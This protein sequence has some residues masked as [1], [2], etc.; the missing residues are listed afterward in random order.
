MHRFILCQ[1]YMMFLL[2]LYPPP[3]Y[4]EAEYCLF[5][6]R[7][8]VA[9]ARYRMICLVLPIQPLSFNDGIPLGANIPLR[10]KQKIWSDQFIDLKTLL[11][12]HKDTNISI[13]MDTTSLS[14]SN[15]TSKGQN[16]LSI[17]QWTTAY[18]TFMAIYIERKPEEAPNLLKYGHTIRELA[19]T[20]GDAAW[21]FY[22]ENFLQLRQTT[23]LPWQRTQS[24][25]MV[26][27]TTMHRSNSKSNTNSNSQNNFRGKPNFPF[28]RPNICY[29][30]NN[31]TNCK[32]SP[33]KYRHICQIC[34]GSHPLIKCPTNAQANNKNPKNSNNSKRGEA[35]A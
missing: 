7:R 18:F 30:F 33:C 14:F 34:R 17:D 13:H 27:A 19:S 11:P 5:C 2:V 1:N 15:P 32:S 23:D 9:V 24:E 6:G 12:N 26:S 4:L 16:T 35:S 22:D 31:G 21:R 10:I 3:P 28:Q 25:L 29:N 20:S 8:R